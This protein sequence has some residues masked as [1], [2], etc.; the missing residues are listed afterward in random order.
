ML[1]DFIK[2]NVNME[3]ITKKCETCGIKN[4]NSK[5]FVEYTSFSY[6]SRGCK[7]LC[8]NKIYQKK[9]HENLKNDFLIHISFLTM[10][11]ICFSFCSGKVLT[12]MT[13]WMTGKKINGTFLP[14]KEGFYSHRNM[15][16]YY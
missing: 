8:C 12:L 1:K 6:N 11:S 13:I 9:F 14:K 15:E 3:R 5:C 2:L 16:V 4:K 7:Y 10:I